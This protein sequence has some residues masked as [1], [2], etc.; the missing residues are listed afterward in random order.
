MGYEN[1]IFYKMIEDSMFSEDMFE[2]ATNDVT[3]TYCKDKHL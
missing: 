3:T 1:N 2:E